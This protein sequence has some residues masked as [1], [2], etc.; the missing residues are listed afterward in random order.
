MTQ[1]L[2]I[3]LPMFA[4][5]IE[6][7]T[8]NELFPVAAFWLSLPTKCPLCQKPIILDYT[9]PKTFKYYKLKCTGT[10]AHCVNLGQKQADSSLYYDARKTW[11]VF[12]PGQDPELFDEPNEHRSTA[13]PEQTLPAG[14]TVA[15]GDVARDRDGNAIDPN[16]LPIGENADI[17]ARKNVLIKLIMDCKAAGIR[18]GILPPDVGAMESAELTKET[19]RLSGLLSKARNQGAK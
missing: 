19:E 18:T 2:K 16:R 14:I 15:R 5:E 12:R 4:V 8:P 10:P 9:T 3:V 7:A 6:G 11:E 1:K 17:S 13:T